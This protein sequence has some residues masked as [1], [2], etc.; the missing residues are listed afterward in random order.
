[1]ALSRPRRIAAAFVVLGL[2]GIV[3]VLLVGGSLWYV[4]G[5]AVEVFLASAAFYAFEREAK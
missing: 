4:L 2:V 1:M 5:I 3:W